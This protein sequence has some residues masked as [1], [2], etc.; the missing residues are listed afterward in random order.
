VRNA[1][2]AAAP[3]PVD[4]LYATATAI[5]APEFHNG[6]AFLEAFEKKFKERPVWGAHYS[7]DAVNALA[8]AAS[9]AETVDPAK[10]VA[11][12]KTK[13]LRTKV[14]HQMRFESSGEQFYASIAVY[15]AERGVWQLQMRSSQW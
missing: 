5:D 6:R 9:S 1:N 7:Y 12:L 2:I 13:E 8:G 11:W 14:N 3:I 10:L 15:K 4:A